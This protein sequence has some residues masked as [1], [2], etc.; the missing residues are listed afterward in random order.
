MGD[1]R[2]QHINELAKRLVTH[3]D[4]SSDEQRHRVMYAQVIAAS[5]IDTRD[6]NE[7]NP[8][9]AE[10][11]PEPE[12]KEL[13]AAIIRQHFDTLLDHAVE[14]A[15]YQIQVHQ[16]G[17]GDQWQLLTLGPHGWT[18]NRVGPR[19][20]AD[21]AYRIEN[22]MRGAIIHLQR[23][24]ADLEG[25]DMSQFVDAINDYAEKRGEVPPASLLVRAG[26]QG[27]GMAEYIR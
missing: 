16:A 8:W 15:T 7:E 11:G 1:K 22:A 10:H 18:G 2:Q 4:A 23:E 27:L 3:G 26:L 21:A 12:L 13:T 19:T 5:Y 20:N 24:D 9:P 6:D 25:L 17:P 14:W